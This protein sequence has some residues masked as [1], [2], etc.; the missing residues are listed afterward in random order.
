MKDVAEHDAD[1]AERELGEA[2]VAVVMRR[3]R[4]VVDGHRRWL[5]R[6]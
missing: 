6:R 4:V 2:V 3:G 5:R 1:R